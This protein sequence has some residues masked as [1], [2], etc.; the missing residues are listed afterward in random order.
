ML[1]AMKVAAGY[2]PRNGPLAMTV[3]LIFT[4]TIT[5]LA[6]DLYKEQ[7]AND[8]EFVQA[9]F[10]ENQDNANPIEIEFLGTNQI[11]KVPANTQGVYPVFAP[12]PVS[13][14]CRTTAPADTLIMKLILLNMPQPYYSSFSVL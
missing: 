7:A 12:N 9:V 1:T 10:V 5:E 13:V 6:F 2:A 8:I 4:P 11:L 3:P 14:R